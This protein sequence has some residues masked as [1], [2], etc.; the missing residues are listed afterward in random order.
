MNLLFM[1]ILYDNQIFATQVYGGVSRLF[2]ELITHLS[3][4]EGANIYLFHGFY[5]N[6]FP[7]ADVKKKLAFYFG[8][9]VPRLP[10]TAKFIRLFNTLLFDLFKPRKNIDIFHP[11]DFSP[12]V[13]RW[14][15]TP[16]VLTVC[17]MIPE[18]YPHFFKDIKTRL[19][20]KRESIQRAD[21]IITISHATKTD[22]LKFH[23]VDEKKVQV[24]Y[25]GVSL[26]LQFN[27]KNE[28]PFAGK[29][30]ILYV[31]TRKQ[32][33]KNFK[34]L[35]SAY[36]AN[37]RI[38][39]LC[40]LVCFGGSPFT[41][42]ELDLASRLG[43]KGSLIWV[44]GD[45]SL[46]AR[47]YAGARVFVYPSLYEGF[48]LPPLEA[49]AYG[50]PVAAS[51]ISSIPE[52]LGDAAL[53]FDPTEPGAISSTVEKVLF[54]GDTAEELVKKGSRRVEKYTWSKMAEET[55]RVYRDVLEVKEE[56]EA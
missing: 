16:L 14:E 43:C 26:P 25:P 1:N 19:K 22:L 17:D 15:K 55:R 53:Y 5:I 37:H 49:M 28:L 35:L 30:Y 9:E 51:G 32:G 2:Y 11:T 31:G 34:N 45:D 56:V 8:R 20:N 10:Y 36:G 39:S 13:R 38:N 44:T 42:D 33:Y 50:C 47:V 29:P 54:Q 23:E 18:L 46:L 4:K 52:V 3:E 40:R 41:A 24:V 12:V 21:R 27:G 7:L 48:G 6:R